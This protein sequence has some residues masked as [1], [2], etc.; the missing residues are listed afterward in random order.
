MSDGLKVNTSRRAQHLHRV[1]AAARYE[2]E[3]GGVT[4]DGVTFHTTRDALSK[5]D[6]AKAAVV[7]GD[8]PDP[9]TWK[10]A[11]GFESYSHAEFKA[12][13]STVRNWVQDVF[14]AEQTVANDIDAGNV[15]TED[16]VRSHSAW[17][18]TSLMT[19]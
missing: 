12:V 10:T 8:L 3:T 4:V 2:L 16:G 15:T 9:L 13:V 6:Q 14:N 18:S 5:L 19:S 11:A 1:A 7:D 17:P